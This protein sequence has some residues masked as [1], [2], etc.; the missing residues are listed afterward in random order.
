MRD[1]SGRLVGVG[2]VPRMVVRG[3]RMKERWRWGGR[4][5]GVSGGELS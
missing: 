2:G 4:E 1:C 3:R 5:E